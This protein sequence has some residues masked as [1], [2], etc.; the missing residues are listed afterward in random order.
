MGWLSLCGL[1]FAL[2][3]SV[4]LTA[5]PRFLGSMLDWTK[6]LGQYF[7]AVGIRRCVEVVRI[8]AR[9]GFIPNNLNRRIQLEFYA[10][11]SVT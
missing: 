11:Y 5:V 1:T 9:R 8:G 10:V 7:I 4:E 6:G 2:M 3:A